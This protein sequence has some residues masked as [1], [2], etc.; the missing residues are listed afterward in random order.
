MASVK[1]AD[2]E[3]TDSLDKFGFC[4]FRV[5]KEDRNANHPDVG[6]VIHLLLDDSTRGR[7]VAVRLVADQEQTDGGCISIYAAAI[8]VFK[9]EE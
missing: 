5:S 8:S 2:K 1:F 3:Q 6:D 9:R 7:R 4:A